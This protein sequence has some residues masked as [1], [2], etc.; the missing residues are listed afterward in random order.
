MARLFRTTLIVF[1]ASLVVMAAGGVV[2]RY[3]VNDAN[4]RVIDR[5]VPVERSHDRLRQLFTGAE[6]SL[7]GYALTSDPEFLQP[8]LDARD[9]LSARMTA[10]IDLVGDDD[11]V[12]ALIG[13]EQAAAERFFDEWGE[14]T[15]EAIA[16]G[17]DSTTV[18][19][20]PASELFGAITDAYNQAALVIAERINDA[21]DRARL[22]GVVSAILMIAYVAA[23]AAASIVV[24]GRFRRG[25]VR[26]LVDLRD[27][28]N[29]L[30]A[31]DLTARAPVTGP[32]EVRQLAE[33]VNQLAQITE[34]TT[35]EQQAR[36]ESN[37]L[38]RETASSIREHLDSS[39]LLSVTVEMIG[40][41]LGGDHAI[42]IRV[43]P[44]RQ[45]GE[46]LGEWRRHVGI[47]PLVGTTLRTPDE[48]TEM[49][50]ATFLSGEVLAIDDVANDSRLHPI[51]VE[52]L[53]GLGVTSLMLAAIGVGDEISGVLVVSNFDAPRPWTAF[54]KSMAG[55]VGRELARGLRLADLYERERDMVTQLQEL[56]QAKADFLSAT[57]HELRT[58]LTSI[59]GYTELLVEGDAGHLEDRQRSMMEVI[60]R[61]ARRLLLL[62]DD[63]LTMSRIDANRLTITPA[64]VGIGSLLDAVTDAMRP[65]ADA[66]GLS[67]VITTVDRAAT[68]WADE[69]AL[70][71][72]LLNLV[73]NA[74]KFTPSGGSVT[75]TAE[76]TDGGLR[77]TVSDTG[78]GIPLDE[79]D[80]LFTRFFRSSESRARAVQGTGLG[81]AIVRHIV[82][83]H[84]GT[85]GVKS[86]P[87]RGTDFWFTLPPPPSPGDE[88][89]ATT[90]DPADMPASRENSP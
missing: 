24:I 52:F 25:V 46:I 6:S 87:G 49:V 56:D 35:A 83:A 77:V 43:S 37:R 58:P 2:V 29:R 63:L 19:R 70:E 67:L 76:P 51:V 66:A 21:R 89:A 71:R 78:V 73:S 9:S 47:R 75:L 1:L 4:S 28:L 8:Y 60:G 80:Q 81:L 34:Q 85:V 30:E 38:I 26:P 31:Q 5:W 36:F 50:T 7:R 82:E 42:V 86:E 88:P 14:P 48:F 40:P 64:N 12:R 59:L 20:T 41:A 17:I 3:V 39:T 57:S 32:T 55:A 72:A 18:D 22:V 11:A 53:A 16:A 69:R 15:R 23:V 65:L 61:N 68:V 13:E 74:I 10:L 54:Q 27:T 62:I 33:A 45:P 79:Q 84:G 90:G 44:D